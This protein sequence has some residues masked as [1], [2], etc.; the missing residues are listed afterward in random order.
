MKEMIQLNEQEAADNAEAQTD[1]RYVTVLTDPNKVILAGPAQ[2]GDDF[3]T[4]PTVGMIAK[5]TFKFILN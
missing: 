1:Q 3:S 4:G 2:F 5:G